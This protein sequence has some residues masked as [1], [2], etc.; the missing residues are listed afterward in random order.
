MISPFSSFAADAS[1]QI[2]TICKQILNS[3]KQLQWSLTDYL[4]FFLQI[5]DVLPH[6]DLELWGDWFSLFDLVIF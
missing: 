5:S 1:N 6:K 4:I 2:E 3:C